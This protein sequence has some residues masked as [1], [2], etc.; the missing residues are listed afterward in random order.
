MGP[1]T[2]RRA[3]LAAALAALAV[4]GAA[5]ASS[6]PAA[7][8]P[9]GPVQWVVGADDPASA[10]DLEDALDAAGASVERLPRLDAL[11]VT[12]GEREAVVDALEDEGGLDYV[13]RDLPRSLHAE[14]ADALDPATGRAFGWAWG[15]VRAGEALAAAGG[16]APSNPVAVVD[17][18]VDRD[19]PDLA[20][21]VTAGRDILG[22]G[23]TQD[24]LGHGTFI[25]GLVSAIDGNGIGGRGVAGA[26]P[27]IPV[28]VTAS[29]SITSADLAAGIVAAVDAGA[30]VVNVSIGGP[31]I[32][33]VEEA[34]L[35][36]ARRRDVLVVASAGNSAQSGNDV[37]YPAAAVGGDDGGW[38]TGLSVAATDPLGRP[39][40]FSSHNDHV[41]IAAPGA[42]VSACA[43]GV[44]STIPNGPASFWPGG[45]CSPVFE[46]PA[47]GAGRY[48]YGR[49]TSFAAPLVAGAGALVRQVAPG[50]RADQVAD[51]LRRTAVQTVGAGWNP[52]TGAGVLDIA[53][54]VALAGRYDV[55]APSLT[56]SAD[57]RSGAVRVRATAQDLTSPGRELA[58][59]AVVG[60]EAS[61]DGESWSQVVAPAAAP[62][63]AIYTASAARPLWVRATACDRSRNCTTRTSGPHTGAAG[64]LRS[65]SASG[66]LRG[67]ILALAVSRRCPSGRATCLRLVVRASGAPGRPRFAVRIRQPGGTRVV[68]ASSGALKPG[69]RRSLTL[70]PRAPLSCGRMVAELT[71][72]SKGRVATA[73][74]RAPVRSC[75]VA[76][77]VRRPTR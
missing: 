10:A 1:M 43:D 70:R 53:G 45:A 14:P 7:E 6:E 59:G 41:S 8:V 28:R 18:G 5:T 61:R 46:G 32:T 4:A 69:R 12:G 68:A 51:V 48:A 17:S 3:A 27:I 13:E 63:D 75:T 19:Q 26:T 66:S 44:Y 47:H 50:L 72:R 25:A 34:A 42:G 11:A 9:A 74:R 73:T 58:A 2:L 29:G 15:A 67:T 23:S 35:D 57:P 77:A 71:V 16:G 65:H 49:G 38:S 76:L 36:Y 22:G 62:I 39:A 64:A 31:G 37:E 21:R 33:S 52:H 54:A 55:T 24:T 30:R 56:L 20:G 40:P 60:L